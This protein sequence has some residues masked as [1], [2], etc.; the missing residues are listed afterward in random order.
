MAP[1]SEYQVWHVQQAR[2]TWVNGQWN[3]AG[4]PAPECAAAS[5][6]TCPAVWNLLPHVGAAGWEVVGAVSRE[7]APTG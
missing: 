6:E 1:A 7:G 4:D 3:G 2:I 5:L